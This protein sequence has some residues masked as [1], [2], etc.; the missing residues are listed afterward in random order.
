MTVDVA[1]H[2]PAVGFKTRGYILT[3]P[4]LYLAIDGDAIV[5]IKANELRQPQRAGQRRCL[6]RDALHQTAVT[7]NH[8]CSVINQ[9]NFFRIKFVSEL[10]LGKRHTHRHRETLAQRPCGGLYP[11]AFTKLRMTRGFRVQ[12]PKIFQILQANVIAG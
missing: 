10:L 6:V 3:E 4:L 1:N 7:S 5:V 9:I 8:P 2:A 12:L 11:W